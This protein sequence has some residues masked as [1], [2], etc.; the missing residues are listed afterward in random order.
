MQHESL[1]SLS[2][3]LLDTVV[4]S[5]QNRDADFDCYI[6]TPI[7]VRY[8]SLSSDLPYLK[9]SFASVVLRTQPSSI[10]SVTM[11]NFLT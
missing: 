8:I 10:I 7:Y 2:R 11:R 9:T 1:H 3:I 6:T 4:L 5:I